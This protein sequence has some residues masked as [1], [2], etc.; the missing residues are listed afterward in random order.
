MKKDDGYDE[1]DK[2][3]DKRE[4]RR[5]IEHSLVTLRW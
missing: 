3:E 5:G 1:L 4:I 2:Q